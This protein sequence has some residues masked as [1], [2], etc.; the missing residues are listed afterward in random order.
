MTVEQYLTDWDPM[1]H[2]L[3]PYRILAPRE[4]A[5]SGEEFFVLCP[6]QGYRRVY[7]PTASE[8]DEEAG[9]SGFRC[10]L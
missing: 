4:D 1:L 5:E 2:R 3:R 10:A 6:E 7:R 8:R 9:A